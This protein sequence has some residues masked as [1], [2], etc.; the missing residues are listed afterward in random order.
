[1]NLV[2]ILAVVI[3]AVSF[4]GAA[5]LLSLWHEDQASGTTGWPLSRVIAYLAV[6]G[7]LASNLLSFV[8]VLRLVDVPNF[9]DIQLALTPLTVT[10]LLVLDVLFTVLALYLRAVRATGYMTPQIRAGLAQESSV[11]EAIAAAKE[12]YTEAN[13]VNQK[14]AR[15]TELVAGKEDKP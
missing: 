10:A 15:L 13:T 1:V 6:A 5:F 3:G 12:A 2:I 14:I 9:R 7:T 8:S 4:G 11:Q